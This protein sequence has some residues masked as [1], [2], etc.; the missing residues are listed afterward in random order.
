M[1]Q[2]IDIPYKAADSSEKHVQYQLN[3]SASDSDC[4]IAE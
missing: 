2:T 4:V 3:L 1:N